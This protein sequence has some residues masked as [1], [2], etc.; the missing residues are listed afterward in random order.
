MKQ[1]GDSTMPPELPP[2]EALNALVSIAIM[3]AEMLEDAHEPAQVGA[4]R[5]VLQLE[6]RL[7]EITSA[8]SPPGGVARAGAVDAALKSR[9]FERASRLRQE[10]FED[11]QLPKARRE[12]ISSMIKNY[13]LA[14][15]RQFPALAAKGALDAVLSQVSNW[16]AQ[17][18]EGRGIFPVAA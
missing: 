1:I 13:A 5:E 11:A 6:T 18:S 8:A 9:Q 7:A 12:E 3:R 15:E 2:A 14:R 17:M 16:R 4:W 10:Y